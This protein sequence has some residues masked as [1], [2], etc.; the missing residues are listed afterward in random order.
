MLTQNYKIVTPKL[1]PSKIYNDR[2]RG[3][4]PM[5]RSR[6]NALS[7]KPSPA[8]RA[9]RSRSMTPSKSGSHTPLRNYRRIIQDLENPQFS[10][11]EDLKILRAWR[12]NKGKSTRQTAQMVMAH[13][14]RDREPIQHRINQVLGKLTDVDI[15]KV[16]KYAKVRPLLSLEMV[17]ADWCRG[18][19]ELW[20]SMQRVT[21]GMFS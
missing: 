13:I 19:L 5:T 4:S 10:I 15:L 20:P 17:I 11:G 8:K 2:T 3:M 1:S 7:Q 16:E 21:T 14:E 12:K 6:T 9:P 18:I